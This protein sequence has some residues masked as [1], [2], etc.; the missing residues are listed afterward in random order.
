MTHDRGRLATEF[1]DARL[2]MLGRLAGEYL[3]DAIGAGELWP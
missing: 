3:A 1:Q 2:E